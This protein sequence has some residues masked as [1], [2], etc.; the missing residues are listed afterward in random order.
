MN[1]TILNWCKSTLIKV[2]A[3]C[4]MAPSHYLNQSSLTVSGEFILEHHMVVQDLSKES[5]FLLKNLLCLSSELSDLAHLPL[6]SLSAVWV[7]AVVPLT[8]HLMACQGWLDGRP[9]A[10]HCPSFYDFAIW[11]CESTRRRVSRSLCHLSQLDSTTLWLNA[12]DIVKCI[13]WNENVAI[14]LMSMS[15]AIILTSV[16]ITYAMISP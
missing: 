2:M 1:A 16:A 15:F 7:V 10:A 14:Y 11:R 3:C 9:G 12:M 8:S 5:K 6:F 13:L 4:Q